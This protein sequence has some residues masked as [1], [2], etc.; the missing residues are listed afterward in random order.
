MNA[1]TR[2]FSIG[3][4]TT[5]RSSLDTTISKNVIGRK[6]ISLKVKTAR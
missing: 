1:E 2:C 5:K 4:Y 6:A 3:L